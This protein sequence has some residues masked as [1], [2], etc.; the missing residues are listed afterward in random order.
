VDSRPGI[1]HLGG[2]PPASP[3][4]RPRR[5]APTV[6]VL[7]LLVLFATA[8]VLATVVTGHL[9][10]ALKIPFS[11]HFAVAIA[12]AVTALFTH[13]M[14]M[15]YFIGTGKRVREEVRDR[16]WNPEI[17]QRTR[18]FKKRVFPWTS[19][20]I[21][22]I[23]TTFILGGGTHTGAIPA[24]IHGTLAWTTLI[25]QLVCFPKQIVALGEN[26]EL[27]DRMSSVAETEDASARRPSA[28]R[29]S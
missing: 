5:E 20:A 12:A 11:G 10:G 27:M 23:M 29:R 6:R 24:W 13:S 2:W 15:F 16:R 25:L 14:V 7:I 26:G 8:G 21:L 19:M 1:D 17:V 4:G 18:V 9:H 22:A 28:D 3:C